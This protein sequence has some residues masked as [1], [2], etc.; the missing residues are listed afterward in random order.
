MR[1]HLSATQLPPASAIS[2][3]TRSPCFS[4]HDSKSAGRD[5]LPRGRITPGRRAGGAPGCKGDVRSG[6]G[7]ELAHHLPPHLGDCHSR[8]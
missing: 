8:A 6:P 2:D 7:D 3:A 4:A 1:L 5:R